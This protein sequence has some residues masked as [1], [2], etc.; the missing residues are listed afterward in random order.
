MS[1]QLM[2]F[3]SF[4]ELRTLWS[5]KKGD[6]SGRCA[7]HASMQE[8]QKTRPEGVIETL[9]NEAAE[10]NLTQQSSDFQEQTLYTYIRVQGNCSTKYP[11]SHQQKAVKNICPG[12]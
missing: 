3:V 11:W 10:P 4:V 5:T 7:S 9:L 6:G 2:A 8:V 12:S 1:G